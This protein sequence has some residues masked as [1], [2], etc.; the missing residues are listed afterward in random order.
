MTQIKGSAKTYT[1]R[2][3]SASGFSTNPH[4]NRMIPPLKNPAD[5]NFWESME[6]AWLDPIDGDWDS[7]DL[8]PL[9]GENLWRA[10][11]EPEPVVEAAQELPEEA[12]V[13]E[14]NSPGGQCFCAKPSSP[15]SHVVRL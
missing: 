12:G 15:A 9:S 3:E 11:V 13:E 6:A 1:Q 8:T 2:F 10:V 5:E 14:E 4:T 7:G